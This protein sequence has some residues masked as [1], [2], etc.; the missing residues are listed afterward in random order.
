MAYLLP[1]NIFGASLDELQITGPPK[2]AQIKSQIMEGGNLLVSVTDGQENPI[3]GLGV[4][5]F[6]I[7]QGIKSAKILSVEPLATRKE[8]GLNVVMVID[9]SMSMKFR[10]AVEPLLEALEAF[11]KT[12]RPIDEVTVVVFDERSTVD[13]NGRKLQ[14]RLF[15]TSDVAALRAF[16]QKSMTEELTQG[17]YLYDAMA[18]GLQA[19]RS[20]PAKSNKFMVVFSDGEDINSIAKRED[21][22]TSAEGI[23]NFSAYTVD[24]MPTPQIDPFLGGFAK[25]TGGRIWKAS[26]AGE[27]LPVFQAFT[28]TILH[29]YVIAYRFLEPPTGKIAFNVPEVTIEEVTTIDSAPLLNYVFF[30]TGK[31]ELGQRYYLFANSA[32]TNAFREENLRGGMEKYRHLLNIIGK[33]LQTNPAANLRLVGCNSGVGEEKSRRDLS[34]QRI[35]TVRSYLQYIWGI[36]PTRIASEARNLPAAPSSNTTPEGRMENQRVEICSDHPALLDTVN[37]EYVQKVSDHD[38]LKIVPSIAS[39]AGIADWKVSLDCG[40]KQ[41]KS[42]QGTGNPP[43]K[44]MVNIDAD[45]MEQIAACD[46]LQS[47]ISATDK[48]ANPLGGQISTMLPVR[49]LQRKERMAQVQG[50]KVKEQYALILFD[51]DS[52]AIKDRN[53]AIVD[54]I[55]KRIAELPDALVAVVGHTDILGKEEYN[56]RLSQRRAAAV[57]TQLV[58][59]NPA[60]ANGLS[61]I[62]VGPNDPLFDNALPEGRALNRTVTITLQYLQK[63]AQ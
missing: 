24:Y 55:V 62:G 50:Y 49:F 10:K 6:S 44:L 40:S 45:L 5:D 16:V 56:L 17:T 61:V 25:Q 7:R 2:A 36:A 60:L 3:M 58:Q 4:K 9:N 63:P 47:T 29:R 15:R 18:A 41:L 34:T 35:G 27:L 1:V 22:E 43:E 12:V 52:A 39:E 8:I 23:A 51:F 28:S 11:Y 57:Q 20:I 32:D 33:R 30:D 38:Q 53:Q 13:W 19:V 46:T 54:R 26:S 48:E 14:A 59:S 21:I 42:F 31:S 37:S